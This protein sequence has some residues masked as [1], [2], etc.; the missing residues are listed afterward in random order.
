MFL[1]LIFF[2]LFSLKLVAIITAC[3]IS[4]CIAFATIIQLEKPGLGL[5]WELVWL[6]TD[7]SSYLLVGLI[8]ILT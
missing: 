3:G 4:V 1:F 8:S 2:F 7:A 6:P 5:M